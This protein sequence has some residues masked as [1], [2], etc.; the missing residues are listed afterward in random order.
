[1]AAEDEQPFCCAWN[2]NTQLEKKF[3]KGNF[4]ARKIAVF[5]GQTTPKAKKKRFSTPK[6][7][8]PPQSETNPQNKETFQKNF[9]GGKILS[10]KGGQHRGGKYFKMGGPP[11][12]VGEKKKPPLKRGEKIFFSSP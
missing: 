4:P 2:G 5:F 7:G 9:G 1:M 6:G 12:C 11:R 8:R 3:W 10:K